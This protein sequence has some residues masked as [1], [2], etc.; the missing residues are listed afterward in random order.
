LF[1]MFDMDLLRII[2]VFIR[3]FQIRKNKNKNRFF[4]VQEIET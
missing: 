2:G 1:L 4:W 3:Y